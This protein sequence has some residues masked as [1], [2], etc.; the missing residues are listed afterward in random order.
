MQFLPKE[1]NITIIVPEYFPKATNVMNGLE[2]KSRE[3]E[4]TVNISLGKR[5]CGG[6]SMIE[7]L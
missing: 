3:T 4:R 7:D 5:R 2:T 1:G 6:G